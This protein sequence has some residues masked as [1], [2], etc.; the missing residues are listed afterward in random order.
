M[1]DRHNAAITTAQAA[2]HHALDG[3]LARLIVASGEFGDGFEHGFGPAGVDDCSRWTGGLQR[4]FQRTSDA[5]FYSS[6]AI[7]RR[8]DQFHAELF[9]ELEVKQFGGGACA[10]KERRWCFRGGERFRERCEWSKAHSPGDHPPLGWRNRLP[11]RDAEVAETRHYVDGLELVELIGAAAC[12]LVEIADAG[13]L[14][15]GIAK[16][17]EDREGAAEQLIGHAGG[18]DH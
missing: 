11:E 13:H 5:S 3:Y 16:H 18:L 6:R 15:G 9:E 17:F 8:Q 14:P 7:F 12:A 2:A 4:S 1:P 10:V